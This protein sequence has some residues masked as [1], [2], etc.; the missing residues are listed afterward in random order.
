MPNFK[1][2]IAFD[3]HL[4]A[5]WEDYVINNTVVVS[6]TC[7]ICDR[8]FAWLNEILSHIHDKHTDYEILSYLATLSEKRLKRIFHGTY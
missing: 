7:K 8:S 1:R 4:M 2:T 3:I 6:R 5:L